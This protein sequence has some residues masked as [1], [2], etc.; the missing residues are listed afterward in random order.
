MDDY[1]VKKRIQKQ[2]RKNLADLQGAIVGLSAVSNF[3]PGTADDWAQVNDVARITNMLNAA[4]KIANG[5]VPA[6]W[7]T[8]LKAG[9]WECQ[10]CG[11]T[12]IGPECPECGAEQYPD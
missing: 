9:E 1:L 6:G 7:D 12:V 3:L 2:Y 11:L 5:L 10:G 8:R 4:S